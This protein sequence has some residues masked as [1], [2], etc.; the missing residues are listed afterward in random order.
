MSVTNLNMILKEVE[1]C[2]SF[3]MEKSQKPYALGQ[4]LPSLISK[5]GLL[6]QAL[7]GHYQFSAGFT[8]LSAG[9]ICVQNLSKTLQF[10]LHSSTWRLTHYLIHSS[11]HVLV[12][13]FFFPHQ[14]F[15]NVAWD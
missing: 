4:G 1:V 15:H 14:A 12:Q 9:P 10:I 3:W 11:Q 5:H 2:K 7:D 6:A 13:Q 8:T